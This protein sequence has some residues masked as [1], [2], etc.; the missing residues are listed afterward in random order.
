MKIE[1]KVEIELSLADIQQ[2]LGKEAEKIRPG[3]VVRS[4]ST[5]V[6]EGGVVNNE[7]HGP[8]IQSITIVMVRVK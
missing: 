4:I 2:W 6:R 8:Y 1:D 5:N 7:E 3:Y